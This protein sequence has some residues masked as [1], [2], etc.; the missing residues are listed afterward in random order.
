MVIKG[1]TGIH[2]TGSTIVGAGTLQENG[3]TIKGGAGSRKGNAN[4]GVWLVGVM[5]FD[6]IKNIEQHH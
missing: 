1:K 3:S 5:A 6:G 4:V 2:G